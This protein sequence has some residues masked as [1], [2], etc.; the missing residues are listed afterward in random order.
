MSRCVVIV[1]TY[2][3]AENLPLLVPRILEQA[4]AIEVLVVDDDSPD[5]T[6]KLALDLADADPRVHV[7]QRSVKQDGYKLILYPKIAKARLYHVKG[8]PH[9]MKD[10]AQDPSR[11]AVMRQLFAKFVAL[12]AEVG[13]SMDLAGVY[14]ALAGP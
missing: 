8:D 4:S 7:L 5:G 14:P 6:G 1:P 12:Q 9:E 2:N 11:L 3:E 13:D 10:L